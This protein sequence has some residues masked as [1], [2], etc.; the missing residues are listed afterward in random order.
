MFAKLFGEKKD[1]SENTIKILQ[2]TISLNKK[3]IEYQQKLIGACEKKAL[4][5]NSKGNKNASLTE[6]RKRKSFNDMN[7][8]LE[9]SIE[10]MELQLIAI[11]NAKLQKEVLTAM[12]Q[13]TKTLKN[14]SSGMLPENI[15][16]VNDDFVECMDDVQQITQIIREPLNI[17]IDNDELMNELEQL[18]LDDELTKSPMHNTESLDNEDNELE[19]LKEEMNFPLVPKTVIQTT[20][21]K[22]DII[23]N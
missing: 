22:R 23:T 15:E 10:K 20:Q 9:A 4:E 1:D 17:G 13:G 21:P 6:M 2:D 12:S 19:K 14:I 3:K 7:N 11:Q 16:K 18:Q 8:A 5:Y